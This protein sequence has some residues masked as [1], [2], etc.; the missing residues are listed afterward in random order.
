[1]SPVARRFPPDIVRIAIAAKY[2]FSYAKRSVAIAVNS[3]RKQ[4][5]AA[6]APNDIILL[7]LLDFTFLPPE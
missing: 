5:S 6:A 3:Q 2:Q 1:M 7:K 4:M